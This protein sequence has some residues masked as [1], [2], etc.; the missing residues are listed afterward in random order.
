M[1]ASPRCQPF[2]RCYPLLLIA[3][4]VRGTLATDPQQ[5]CP[6]VQYQP[7]GLGLGLPN[8]TARGTVTLRRSTRL[9][10]AE[11]GMF[12]DVNNHWDLH[13]LVNASSAE[14]CA[15]RCLHDDSPG[16]ADATWQQRGWACSLYRYTQYNNTWV[17]SYFIPAF[18]YCHLYSVQG[19]S[20]TLGAPVQQASP[21]WVMG[22]RQLS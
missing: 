9:W 17:G 15:L 22:A 13:R 8:G 1:A 11:I 16:L 7:A 3:F 2:W 6:T 18:S 19:Y 5:S 21:L 20:G 10:Y 14:D 4:L 12:G